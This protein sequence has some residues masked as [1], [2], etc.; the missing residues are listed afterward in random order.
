MPALSQSITD[1]RIKLI[2][3]FLMVGETH[4]ET[5]HRKTLPQ[6]GYRAQDLLAVRLYGLSY[7]V[8][9]SLICWEIHVFSCLLGLFISYSLTNL[10][11]EHKKQ[12][13]ACISGRKTEGCETV[14]WGSS[15]FG[16]L[17]SECRVR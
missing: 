8:S 10:K 12:A 14:W 6:P 2:N 5:P 4:G 13:A 9:Y 17:R 7:L 16:V 3:M 15:V 11:R 1:R